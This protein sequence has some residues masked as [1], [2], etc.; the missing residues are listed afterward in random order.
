MASIFKRGRSRFWYIKYYVHGQQVYRSL[1]TTSERV[2][3]KLQE[4]IEAD[5]VRGDLVAPSVPWQFRDPWFYPDSRSKTAGSSPSHSKAEGN[6]LLS[7][8]R[9]IMPRLRATVS[10]KRSESIKGISPT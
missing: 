10:P 2:A 1:E 7:W 9:T 3:R 8:T 6:S 4:Q 5:E